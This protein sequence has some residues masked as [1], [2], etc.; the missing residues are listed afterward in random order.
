MCPDCSDARTVSRSA[1]IEL[2]P[3]NF[4]DEIFLNL[5]ACSACGFRGAIVA[6]E[7]RGHGG[8]GDDTDDTTGY[9]LDPSSFESIRASI[10][11]CPGPGRRQCECGTHRDL[12]LA[13]TWGFLKGYESM[14]TFPVRAAR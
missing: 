8:L 13:S 5:V 9:R 4:W 12:V 6:L 7:S 11:R 2:R 14:G 3:D 10:E 1:A